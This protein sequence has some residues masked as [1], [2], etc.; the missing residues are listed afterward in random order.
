MGN[1]SYTEGLAVANKFF[2]RLYEV[3]R[4]PASPRWSEVRGQNPGS[5]GPWGLGGFLGFGLPAALFPFFSD[6]G[7]LSTDN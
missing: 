2:S 6:N 1:G 3:G 7:P 4:C 5:E